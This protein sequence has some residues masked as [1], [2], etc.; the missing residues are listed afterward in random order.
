MG[1]TYNESD[2]T[3]HLQTTESSYIMQI[4]NEGYVSHLH[5]GK[6]VREGRM[7][8][9][10]RF[11]NR[12]FSPNP[13]KD[14]RTFSLDTLPQE[15]P[16]YGHTD[17][18]HPAVHI[19]QRNGSRITDLRYQSHRI[20]PGKPTLAG[21]PAT[22]VEDD[23]EA[24]TLEID[25]FDEV[26]DLTVTLQYTVY[27]DRN[28]I[29]RSVL[30]NNQGEET[31]KLDR[32]QSMNID[33]RDTNFEMI[34]L[35]GS[36]PRERDIERLPL[37]RG[38]QSV[39]SR[40]GTSSHHQN[41]FVALTRPETTESSGEVYGF[42]LIYSGNFKAEI[43]VDHS[44]QTRINMG[45]NEFDFSWKLN[46]NEQFQTPEVALVYSDQGLGGMSRT[47]HELYGRRLARG[48]HRDLERPVLINNWEATYFNFNE[49]KILEI[50]DRAKDTGIELF[51]LDDGWFGNRNSDHSS[52][53][54]WF[55]DKNK[56]PNG[57]APL[58][59][60]INEKGM[61]FGLWFE[62]EMVSPESNLYKEHPDW[63]IHVPDR[64][65]SESRS[66]LVL[67]FSRKE[68]CDEIIKRVVDV[69][70]SAPIDY[71]KWDMNRNLTE[72]GSAYWPK[73]QQKEVAHRF[74][75]GL[76]YVMETITEQFPDILFESCSGG[77][78]RY[79]PGM[80]YYMPQ[81][82]TS[83]NTDAI[84]RL[85]IQYGTSLV[86]P[87]SSMGAHVS[88]VPNHQVGR[89]TP[90]TTRGHV[91]MGGNLGYELDVTQLSD[92]EMKIIKNQIEVYKGIRQTIQY[93]DFYRLVSPFETQNYGT[94]H[95]SK[96]QAEAVFTY[97]HV[98]AEATGPFLHV[99][100]AG[101]DPERDYHVKELDQVY[102]GDEL[103]NIG[104][105][106]PYND[107]DF[108]STMYRLIAVN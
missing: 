94:I 88:A 30:F 58:A 78:G 65:R 71:V 79:D 11:M 50:A 53:G 52:L 21:L 15:Y 106:V 41:P 9:Q 82:W 76:Y 49:K 73:D 92:N 2:K 101:L 61:K 77:G 81:I 70:K 28:V 19:E 75:L 1:I 95:V 60:A 97:V 103:M 68:V 17:F 37:R 29:T 16:A 3:F 38:M 7:P 66:Q 67:D 83:D 25:L 80:L 18:R 13:N 87:I 91:A 45:I 51:V 59:K 74:V 33:F 44:Y 86:Y 63:C 27:N 20:N 14:D 57:L 89:T 47:Y 84:S 6:K 40:R 43:E 69:L 54:D 23:K 8:H 24:D 39:E 62:P 26:I 102:G 85:R 107:H 4:V 100:L 36:Q 72:I 42:S 108:K 56:L 34:N 31:L 99:R 96:D 98:L 55:V 105:N 93:G 46:H 12:G 22:Y 90:L 64:R 48:K 5:W 35:P 10:L 104:I 32:V